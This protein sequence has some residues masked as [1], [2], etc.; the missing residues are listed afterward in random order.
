M[1]DLLI[2]IFIL[3]ALF[4]LVAYRFKPLFRSRNIVDY[5]IAKLEPVNV[6]EY[7]SGG[8]GRLERIYY[9]DGNSELMLKLSGTDLP[10]GSTLKLNVN[11]YTVREIGYFKGGA[12]FK[13]DS[14]NGTSVPYITNG[15]R[16]EIM[17]DGNPI[18][19]GFSERLRAR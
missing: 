15:D 18:L 4:F 7:V 13:M 10:R 1:D 17:L 16:I 5:Y 9:E 12:S 2:Y 8:T 19:G 14:R 6:N 11:G 3:S